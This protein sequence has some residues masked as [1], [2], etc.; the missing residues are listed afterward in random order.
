MR[1]KFQ[2]KKLYLDAEG[3]SD[4][5]RRIYDFLQQNSVGVLATVSLQG[6][7]HGTV[8]YYIIDRHFE[9]SFLTRSETQKYE[10]LKYNHH[11][12]LTVF[13]TFTQTT[14]QL[15]GIAEELTDSTDINAVAGAVLGASLKSNSVGLQPITKLDAGEYVAF[16][17]TPIQARM[18]VYARPDGGSVE[19]MIESVESFDLFD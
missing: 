7:P 19:D 16:R 12:M 18:A 17:I 9:V 8:I 5:K 6:D 4:R 1:T 15:A 3:F 10:N 11:V 14:V 2:T 13:D